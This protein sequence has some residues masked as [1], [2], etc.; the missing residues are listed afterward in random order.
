MANIV[1]S[2]KIAD[3]ALSRLAET[4]SIAAMDSM[5]DRYD[6]YRRRLREAL[7][8]R[9]LTNEAVAE[10]LNAHP[11]TVS[12]LLNGRLTLNEEWRLRFAEALDLS[13]DELFGKAPI[14]AIRSYAD[15]PP[16]EG[17]MR[18]LP[19]DLPV[20]GTAAGSHDRGAFQLV[21]GVVDYVMR[22]P[23]L[24]GA[25]NAYALYV[26]NDSMAPEHN[27]GDL[28]F[29]HPDRPVRPGDSVIVQTQDPD[30]AIAATI[31]HLVR[32]SRHAVTIGKLNPPAEI[33]LD[34]VTAVHK[35]LTTNEL[36]GV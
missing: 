17:V 20:Y 23:A 35:V 24:M 31:G 4:A 15:T 26:E 12:K 29:I 9:R 22:P 14:P 6:H 27:H 2:H 33:E 7:K 30:G 10:R 32:R 18:D 28:R 36:F 21:G 16:V 1:S 25:R 3:A 5:S 11:V 8:V 13:Y 19:R 34:A